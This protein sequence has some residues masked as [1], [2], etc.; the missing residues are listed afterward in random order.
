M[1]CFDTEK[2]LQALEDQSHL[3]LSEVE[4]AQRCAAS[5]HAAHALA[6][7]TAQQHLNACTCWHKSYPRTARVLGEL[8]L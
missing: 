2:R 4:H 3:L 7:R 6:L 5:R 1:P 8:W